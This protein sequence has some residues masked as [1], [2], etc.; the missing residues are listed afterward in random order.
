MPKYLTRR[1]AIQTGVITTGAFAGTSFAQQLMGRNAAPTTELR[2][3]GRSWWT[4]GANRDYVRNLKPGPTPVRLACMSP[5]TMMQYPKNESIT[6]VVKRIREKG[7]TATNANYRVGAR[8]AW[9][10]ASDTEIRELKTAL[11]E[12]D[13]DFYD[14]MV[15][16]NLLH[17]DSAT[18]QKNIKYVCEAFEAGDR[19]GVRSITG[20]TGSCGTGFYT[21]FHPDNWTK[22]TWALTVSVMKQILRDT[23]GCKTVWGMEQCITTNIDGPLPTKQLLEDVADPRFKVVLDP[24]NMMNLERYFRFA[25]VVDEAFDLL[26]ENIVGCHAKDYR[27]GTRMLIDLQEV[28]PGKGVQDYEILLARLS[29]LSWPRTL[30]LEHFPAEE[31][32]PAREYFMNTATKVGVKIYS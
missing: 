21:E 30:M 15:W 4:P 8:N 18:R 1:R 6:G 22:E 7:Y 12:Y 32:P 27:L 2:F 5:E 16:T 3:S 29:R 31:Y 25:E 19:C 13:V 23:A 14:I 24:T 17:P 11:K 28:P 10:D 9:L 20:I 26:G